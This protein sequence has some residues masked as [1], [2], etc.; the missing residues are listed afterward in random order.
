[1]ITGLISPI[2]AQTNSATKLAEIVGNPQVND[3]KITV[4][5][6]IKNK[7]ERP[8]MGLQDT[9]FK[10]FVNDKELSFKSQDW[11]SPDESVP[12]PAWIVVLLD[13]S[14]SMNKP[15]SRGGKKITG[16]INAIRRFT[17]ISSDRGGSTNIAIVPFGKSG[18]NCEGYTVN[19]DTLDKFFLAND[20]K[21]QNSLN[22]LASIKPCASTDLYQPL[23]QA[24][25]FLGN[26]KDPRFY[27]E[28][29]FLNTQPRLAIILLSDGY[30]N[31]SNEAEDFAT[32]SNLLK[33]NTN[34]TVHTL[35]YGLTPQELGRKYRLGRPATR[36]DIG[37]GNRKVPEDEFVDQK[38]LA[39]IAKLTGGIAEFSGDAEAIAENLKLFM[40]ALLGEYQISYIQP[41]AERG[42]QHNVRVQVKTPIG[43]L[44]SEKKSYRIRGIGRSL[45]LENRL[46][47]IFCILFLTGIGGVLPFYYWGK[48][49]KQEAFR[50]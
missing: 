14:G 48:Y 31:A 24:V 22:Y 11:K 20:F 7:D 3:D 4:R 10:L 13:F 34:I 15:D 27:P 9:D 49:L 1:M 5:M 6:K 42:S 38:R 16:A 32:L 50:D 39:E 46:I 35:G 8:I 23:T 47:M 21:L 25:R 18:P 40:N 2:I 19:K 43:L 28:D 26:T 44:K 45:P 33:R 17:K 12:P 29:N 30:H 41:N 36:R 37:T